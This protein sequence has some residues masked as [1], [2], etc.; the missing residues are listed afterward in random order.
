MGYP[1]PGRRLHPRLPP[2]TFSSSS[3][4]VS[5]GTRDGEAPGIGF[6]TSATPAYAKPTTSG[7][8]PRLNTG[9]SPGVLA[10]WA[11]GQAPRP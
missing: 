7:T 3:P 9:V 8:P 1:C 6:P 10:A 11:T 2:T 4:T 5:Q